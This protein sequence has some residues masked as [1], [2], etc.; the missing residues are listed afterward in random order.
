MQ[1]LHRNRRFALAACGLLLFISAAV[2]GMQQRNPRLVE[3]SQPTTAAA[4]RPAPRDEITAPGANQVRRSERVVSALEP[5]ENLLDFVMPHFTGRTL[6][7]ISIVLILTLTFQTR[8]LL[9]W[10]NLDGIT[11]AII[12]ILL[13]LRGNTTPT[14]F[15][16]GFTV[17]WWVYAAMSVIAGYWLL[18]GLG[19]FFSERVPMF[20]PNVSEGAM[21]V[22]LI[23]GLLIAFN[24]ILT[25][26]ASA[27]S[28]DAMIGGLGI[29]ETGHLPYGDVPG[30]D[31]QSPLLYAV[32][33]AAV[34][35][36]PPFNSDGSQFSW[37]DRKQL[38]AQRFSREDTPVAIRLVNATLF[39]LMFLGILVLGLKHHS[40]AM[41]QTISAI[42]CIFPGATECLNQ[43]ELMLPAVLVTWS[44]ALAGLPLL[45]GFG[46]VL[47]LVLAGVVAPWAWLALPLLLAHFF[48]RGIHALGALLGLAAGV[49]GVLFGLAMHT[50]PTLP[51]VDGAL[52]AANVSPLYD[53]TLSSTESK[54]VL[55][56]AEPTA[57]SATMLSPAWKW[58]VERDDWR[59]GQSVNTQAPAGVDS[60]MVR[61]RELTVGETA[62][63]GL[64]RE[65]R[66]QFSHDDVGARIL[67]AL[68]TVLEATALSASPQ[69]LEHPGSWELWAGTTGD[70]LWINIR[71]AAKV[72]LG[73]LAFVLAF[74]LFGGGRKPA[75]QLI[76][77]MLT[78]LAGIQLVSEG[79]AATNL[80]WM[81][82][83]MLAALA[84]QNP[85]AMPLP[86]ATA[87]PGVAPRIT[88]TR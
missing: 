84:V 49:A 79:G 23:A 29:V 42:F 46:S 76:G 51:R 11:L 13:P 38:A 41:A 37:S 7:W 88:V 71:R 78:L 57:A 61:F 10:H 12:T 22:L 63:E 83:A 34:K 2:A 70:G 40:V 47:M 68:R 33:A 65:Y 62:R 52:A 44:L 73:L 59:L 87:G 72:A 64:Q 74:L 3:S 80:V 58:L 81:T 24:T 27:A 6:T 20:G 18:R 31:Q 5:A 45:G 82:P 28:R 25:M 39:F 15:A 30:S 14:E 60:A 16:G 48:R 85:A 75:H 56:K 1:V 77:G 19:L 9:S 55:T 26:P 50:E 53:I 8:P 17:Q 66:R 36:A 67:P 69:R 21:C 54:Y 43:P 86:V 35:V 4:T 32:H